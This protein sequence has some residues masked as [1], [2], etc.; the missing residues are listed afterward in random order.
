MEIAVNALSATAPPPAPPGASVSG[1]AVTPP[2][3]PAQPPRKTE[4]PLAS[5]PT[6]ARVLHHAAAEAAQP[7]GTAERRHL[8]RRCRPRFSPPLPP[9]LPPQSDGLAFAPLELPSLDA[10][11]S[12]ST[13][14]SLHEAM[15][16]GIEPCT[17]RMAL[18][19]MRKAA[20]DTRWTALPWIWSSWNWCS[21]G[22]PPPG[23]ERVPSFVL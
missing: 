2:S 20:A 16:S 15:S 5:A 12:P 4:I 8:R 23:G 11:I 7:A 22:V 6:L 14:I 21:I 19:S 3:P 1:A 9:V 18:A 17:R 13:S 10:S